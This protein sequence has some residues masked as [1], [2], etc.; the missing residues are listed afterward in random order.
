MNKKKSSLSE[1]LILTL[2]EI[3]VSLLVVGGFFLLGLQKD[4]S[5]ISIIVGVSVGSLVIIANY[6]FLRI[7]VNRQIN[8]YLE[9]RGSRE[10]TPEEI[11]EFTTKHSLKIQNTIKISF[12]VRMASMVGALVVAFIITDYINPLA[13]VIPI[14]AYRPILSFGEMFR[15]KFNKT[16]DP[17]NFITYDT[18]ADGFVEI[19]DDDSD[20]APTDTPLDC[21]ELPDGENSSVECEESTD[22][23]KEKESDE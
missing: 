6:I 15:K 21:G 13:T 19:S 8:S 18:E 11:L 1:I 5:Y 14:L 9:L 4:Y 2:G 10:M 22:T 16:P 3:L 17:K 20:A 12:L 7:T 23:K